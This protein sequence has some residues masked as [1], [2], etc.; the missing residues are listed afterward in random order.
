[1]LVDRRGQTRKVIDH[2]LPVSLA[3]QS[4]IPTA[5]A[6]TYPHEKGKASELRISRGIAISE[7]R[8]SVQDLGQKRESSLHGSRW[9]T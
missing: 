6:K 7:E 2:H 3:A 5:V 1:M 4:S 9:K 8:Q